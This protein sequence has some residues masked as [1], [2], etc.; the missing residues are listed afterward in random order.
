MDGNLGRSTA[1]D[2]L[3]SLA[4][5]SGLPSPIGHAFRRGNRQYSHVRS[6]ADS[7]ARFSGL[8]G[9]FAFR[10]LRRSLDH[11]EPIM[12]TPRAMMFA[13]VPDIRDH[14]R[15]IPLAERHNAIPGLPCKRTAPALPMIYCMRRSTLQI[16]HPRRDFARWRQAHRHVHMI[17]CSADRMHSGVL[18][19][20]CSMN[21][22]VVRSFLNIAAQ[23][24]LVVFGTPDQV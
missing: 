21:Q 19:I 8:L 7:S 1:H 15:Q 17:I 9:V 4:R 14:P 12:H 10:H 6:C 13:L 5:F 3:G 20:E 16:A 22:L 24:W 23:H 18:R 11:L 2:A